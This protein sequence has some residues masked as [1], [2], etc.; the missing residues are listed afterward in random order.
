ML[1]NF[2]GET[3]IVPKATVLGIAEEVSEDILN[4]VNA[5]SVS[6]TKSPAKPPRKRKNEHLYI[7][8]LQGKLDH[9]KPKEIRHIEPVLR[10]YA[11]M[12]HDENTN[13]FKG[14]KVTEHQILVGEASPIR[15][16]HTK[17]LSL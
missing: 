15:K 16:P 8:L 13:D 1:A 17:R 6:D 3:L 9:L 10:K 12:F 11:H 5:K 2:S 4:R 14:T 7:H